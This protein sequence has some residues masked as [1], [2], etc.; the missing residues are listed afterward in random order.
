MLG[1]VVLLL[2]ALIAGRWARESQGPFLT[3]YDVL[4]SNL[5]S[6]ALV[7]LIAANVLPALRASAAIVT[8]F[9]VV[10]GA[11]GAWTLRQRRCPRPSTILGSGCTWGP[12][13]CSWACV[14]RPPRLRYCC[15]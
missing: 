2:G 3:L 14:F 1:V 9:L 13:S 7:F 11:W 12:E 15:S 8:V 10:L 4:V 6:L 5:F